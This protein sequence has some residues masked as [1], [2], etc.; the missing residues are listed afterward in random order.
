MPLVTQTSFKQNWYLLA[1]Q[2]L[3]TIAENISLYDD[4]ERKAPDLTTLQMG[5]QFLELLNRELPKGSGLADPKITVSPNGDL[6]ITIGSRPQSLNVRFS[7]W[8][9]KFLFKHPTLGTVKGSGLA[10]SKELAIQHFQ[11]R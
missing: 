3:Q 5:K 6:V 11:T 10:E 4:E 2:N 1:S 9:T 7:G 8:S